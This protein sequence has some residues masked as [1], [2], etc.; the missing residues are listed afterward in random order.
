[1]LIPPAGVK[2]VVFFDTGGAFGGSDEYGQPIPFDWEDVRLSAGFG[3]RWNS[4]MGPLRFE[5]GFPLGRRPYEK[6]MIFEF[7]IGSFF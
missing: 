1:P 2:G 5:W 4:P 7:T 6:P 3:V